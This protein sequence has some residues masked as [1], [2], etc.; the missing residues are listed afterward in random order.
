M[1]KL[2]NVLRLLLTLPFY[3]LHLSI[4]RPPVSLDLSVTVSPLQPCC[5]LGF[6]KYCYGDGVGGAHLCS[7][8]CT[9]SCFMVVN[10][11]PTTSS[12]SLIQSVLPNTLLHEQCCPN[13][14][15][16]ST[17]TGLGRPPLF[18]PVPV[19]DPSGKSQTA[20]SGRGGWS[21]A[22]ALQ[23]EQFPSQLLSLCNTKQPQVMRT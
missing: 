5:Q 10:S 21:I 11:N 7:K 20:Y 19:P 22:Q 18:P 2:L 15:S 6:L 3:C 12:Q 4:S 23:D 16:A 17:A 9:I 13:L 8:L 1:E 14:A